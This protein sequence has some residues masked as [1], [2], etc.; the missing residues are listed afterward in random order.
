MAGPEANL[1]AAVRRNMPKDC[2]ANR[3]ENLSGGGIPDVHMLLES[4]PVW[5]ELKVAKF[6]RLTLSPHQIAWHTAYNARKGLS[7]FLVKDPSSGLFYLF[8][9]IM[10][11][12]LHKNPV[13]QVQ[14][15]R[16]E[17][18]GSLFCALRAALRDHYEGL[19]RPAR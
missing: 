14:G 19:L 12:D 8:S 7:F 16:F 2:M 10:A 3:I 15:S 6:R 11:V 4:M 13:D 9:G 17:D 18:L 1:W 5:I